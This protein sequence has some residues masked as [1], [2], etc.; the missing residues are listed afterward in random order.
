MENGKDYGIVHFGIL[1]YTNVVVV[2]TLKLSL[3]VS[4]WTWI[5]HLLIWGCFLLWPLFIPV[6]E[7]LGPRWF[8]IHTFTD[9]FEDCISWPLFWINM[10][11]TVI[12]CLFRDFVWRYISYRIN[13]I[14]PP[15]E[16]EKMVSGRLKEPGWKHICSFRPM[17]LLKIIQLIDRRLDKPFRM[18][19]MERLPNGRIPYAERTSVINWS[20][21]EREM[22]PRVRSQSIAGPFHSINHE[23]V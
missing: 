4:S 19:P 22:K 16:M 21:D 8:Q 3:H 12:L 9:A 11:G 15:E 2:I 7:Q 5:H 10:L 13:P 6:Y 17:S 18:D 1:V 14:L 23:R 20:K